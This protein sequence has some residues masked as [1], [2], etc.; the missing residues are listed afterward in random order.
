MDRMLSI[1]RADLELL[2]AAL[3]RTGCCVA[4]N[5]FEE[6]RE[7]IANSEKDDYIILHVCD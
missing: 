1:H 4:Y 7:A 6:L 2:F 5:P 3:P